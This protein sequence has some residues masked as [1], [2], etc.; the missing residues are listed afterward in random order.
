MSGFTAA[1]VPG[2]VNSAKHQN[3]DSLWLLNLFHGFQTNSFVSL[4]P[5]DWLASRNIFSIFSFHVFDFHAFCVVHKYFNLIYKK[6]RNE[7]ENFKYSR[8]DEKSL[9]F[10]NVLRDW[11]R[12]L[13]L[14]AARDRLWTWKNRSSRRNYTKANFA[15]SFYKLV[16]T[17]FGLGTSLMVESV[18]CSLHRVHQPCCGR[19]SRL[20]I[21]LFPNY[22][23]LLKWLFVSRKLR[24][25]LN[26]NEESN[27]V[28]HV[29]TD[30]SCKWVLLLVPADAPSNKF[31]KIVFQMS[32][33]KLRSLNKKF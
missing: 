3:P 6:S 33:H 15:F 32:V 20:A 1:D 24:V 16:S 4:S 22:Y 12:L 8:A 25:I 13:M 9:G 29:L 28:H 11:S 17:D 10:R 30:E 19:V 5:E 21:N 2:F 27:V 31:D 23:C 26:W 14:M 7:N 18:F